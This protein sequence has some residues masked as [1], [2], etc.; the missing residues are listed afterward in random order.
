MRDLELALDDLAAH[1]DVPARPDLAAAVAAEL[2]RAPASGAAA[3]RV[4]GPARVPGRP[5]RVAG[6]WAPRRRI[7]AAAAALV[8][9]TAAGAGLSPAIAD[10]L[11]LRG[12]RISLG[13]DA[14]LPTQLGGALALGVPTRLADARRQVPFRVLLPARAEVGDPDEVYVNHAAAEPQLALVWRSRP[15]LP[16]AATTG[17]GMLLTEFR[18]DLGA[19]QIE[20][21]LGRQTQLEGLTVNGGRALWLEGAP[22]AFFYRD[23][24]GR[25]RDETVRLAANVLLWEQGEVTLRL[26][27]VLP[28]AEAVRIA[29]TVR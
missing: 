25:V 21:V 18:G 12:V 17:V 7:A 15:E 2:R 26:E 23:A 22:H 9:V 14:E 24:Q 11:G 10:R 27:S 13:G 28:R 6:W 3:L 29:E 19:G 8:A 20:K 5:A 4:A 16:E 1:L